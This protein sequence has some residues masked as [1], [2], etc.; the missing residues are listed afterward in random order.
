MLRSNKSN[1]I[2]AIII[3]FIFFISCGFVLK[4]HELWRDEMAAY[5]L[6][7]DSLNLVDLFKNVRYEGHSILWYVLLRFAHYLYNSVYSMQILSLL[8][9]ASSVFVFMK[10]SPFKLWQKLLFV[11]GFWQFFEYTIL[12]R[13]YCL[14]VFLLF[15]FA[16]LYKDRY[17][18]YGLLSLVII[19]LSFTN[20]YT[21]ITAG[22]LFVG[23]IYDYWDSGDLPFLKRS[24]LVYFIIFTSIGMIG[25]LF[26]V[27]PPS[28][29]FHFENMHAWTLTWNPDYFRRLGDAF[30]LGFIALIKSGPVYWDGGIINPKF[31]VDY[32]L[33][34]ILLLHIY[35]FFLLRKQ[36]SL[37]VTYLVFIL[38]FVIFSYVFF[39]GGSQRHFGVL[40]LFWL[41]LLWMAEYRAI[42]EPNYESLIDKR[43]INFSLSFFLVLQFFGGIQASIND[44]K[45]DFSDGKNL[46]SFFKKTGYLDDDYIIS[47]FPDWT[48]LSVIGYLPENIKFYYY[49]G[50]LFNTYN[51]S[52][53]RRTDGGPIENLAC[54]AYKMSLSKNKKI[55]LILESVIYKMDTDLKKFKPIYVSKGESTVGENYVVLLFDEKSKSKISNCGF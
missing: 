19:L 34:L 6:S 43:I 28:D 54:E 16:T 24:K 35:T 7:R 37:L 4:Y 52:D 15:T 3:T 26:Q 49:H 45:Y 17:K 44:L 55:I 13:D 32:I 14:E 50:K 9:S 10:F 53:S 31:F 2:F 47:A 30:T 18:N 48:G 1:N 23:L 38:S 25:A 39:Q 21:L 29:I 36:K 20:V 22:A 41:V 8:I 40:F 27:Y 12:S 46:A 11:F 51:V 42:G 33:P 5:L